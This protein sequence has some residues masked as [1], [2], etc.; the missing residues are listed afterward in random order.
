M[1]AT[2]AGFHANITPGFAYLN[3][4]AAAVGMHVAADLIKLNCAG[5]G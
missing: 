4:T 1:N 3:V 2:A 5:A